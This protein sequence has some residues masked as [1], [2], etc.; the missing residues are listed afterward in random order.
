MDDLIQLGAYVIII[1]VIGGSSIIKKIIEARKRRLEIEEQRGKTMRLD[2]DRTRQAE[3]QP[4]SRPEEMERE[5][6]IESESVEPAEK[7]K[8]EEIL[9]EIFNIPS[10]PQKRA[11]VIKS[12]SRQKEKKPQ[13]FIRPQMVNTDIGKI[14]PLQA[15]TITQSN[16]PSWEVFATGLK[17]RGLNEIQRAIVMSE[18]I[19]KPKSKRGVF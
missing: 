12:V 10:V 5:I 13:P 4:I 2:V 11:D 6:V 9:K 1:L 19:Q 15:E 16:E 3:E 7:P 17:S 18:I 14:L 8:I